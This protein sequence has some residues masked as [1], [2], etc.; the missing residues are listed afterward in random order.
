MSLTTPPP[1]H[2]HPPP[3]LAPCP[4]L[5]ILPPEPVSY[6]STS[7]Q[8][9]CHFSGPGA[10]ISCSVYC[11]S[12]SAD[13]PASV[14]HI[15]HYC[16]QEVLPGV[17]SDCGAPCIHPSPPWDKT[18]TPHMAGL[19]HLSHQPRLFSQPPCRA[20]HFES[21][22]FLMP[23]GL[24]TCSPFCPPPPF[25]AALFPCLAPALPKAPAGTLLPLGILPSA[26]KPL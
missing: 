18:Q 4:G 20:F 3:P 8:P 7:L 9:H 23:R 17:K 10:I 2:T 22:C 5:L 16:S 1:K 6:L 11:K 13:F 25:P 19:A 15:T 12:L 21:V 14:Q 26:P 24:C